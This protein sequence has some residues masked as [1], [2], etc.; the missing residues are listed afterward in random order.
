MIRQNPSRKLVLHRPPLLVGGKRAMLRRELFAEQVEAGRNGIRRGL[1]IKVMNRQFVKPATEK[2]SLQGCR[3]ALGQQTFARLD[4]EDAQRRLV[5]RKNQRHVQ[6]MATRPA[7][8]LLRRITP[9]QA[10]RRLDERLAGRMADTQQLNRGK[11]NQGTK[12]SDHNGRLTY[13]GPRGKTGSKRRGF[14]LVEATISLTILTIIGLVMLKLSLNILLPRQWVLLQTL[15]DAHMT[16][17]RAYAERIPFQTLTASTSP[18][19]AYPTTTSTQVSLGQLPGGTA[20]TGTLV[21]TRL[22]DPNNY[23]IDGGSGTTATN[24]A[25][26]KVWQVQSVLTYQ[27]G[28]RTYAKSRTVIRSQ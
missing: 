11:P 4:L 2:P 6:T 7:K 13:P 20:V 3:L 25:S 10:E 15:T 24:P 23:P 22:P 8:Q 26:M 18:W 21:R 28:G 9:V 19:P 14:L 1:G 12:E 16:Y 27:I 5:A 17:E